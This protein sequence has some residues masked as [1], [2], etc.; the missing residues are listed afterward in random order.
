M[1]HTNVSMVPGRLR[2][3]AGGILAGIGL[4]AAGPASA[5]DSAAGT[6]RGAQAEV[7]FH[8]ELVE[9]PPCIVNGGE[10][11]VVDFGSEVMT[12]RID[13]TEYKKRIAFTLDCREAVSPGQQL[14]ITGG[15]AAAFDPQAIAGEQPG[16]GIA[17]YEGSHR[18]TPGDWLPFTDPAVPE[19]YAVPVKQDGVTLSG[20]AFS[21][22][23]SLVVA[24]N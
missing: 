21:I 14:R 17:L 18:Y 22:L 11:V 13:G 5:A 3:L 20:G 7:T 9:A 10:P 8:G 1:R 6:P 15:T 12:T 23:A 4:L 2:R 16:F 24:Y 19:L